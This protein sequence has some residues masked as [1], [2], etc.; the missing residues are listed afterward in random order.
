MEIMD[1][2]WTDPF[3]PHLHRIP[4]NKKNMIFIQGE[5]EYLNDDL[6]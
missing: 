4:E 6:V 2:I 1:F 3:L 5:T